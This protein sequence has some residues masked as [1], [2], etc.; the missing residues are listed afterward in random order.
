MLTLWVYG[1]IT[2]KH[3]DIS[4]THYID[5]GGSGRPLNID[6][7]AL[8]RGLGAKEHLKTEFPT[9]WKPARPLGLSLSPPPRLSAPLSQAL[10]SVPTA[11][12]VWVRQCSQWPHSGL[13]RGSLGPVQ[14]REPPAGRSA[15]DRH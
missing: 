8:S 12:I 10:L 9:R 14:L 2:A 7:L 15:A 4:K 13:C 3:P 11:R 6:S 1:R 5:F